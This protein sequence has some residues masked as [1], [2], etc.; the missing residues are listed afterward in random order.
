M[1]DAQRSLN[2]SKYCL[3]VCYLL[4]FVWTSWYG[5][6]NLSHTEATISWDVSGYYL[7]L[8]ATFIYQDLEQL[9]FFEE[10]L[11]TYGP[12]AGF[13][14]AFEHTSGNYILKYTLGQAILYAPAFFVAHWLAPVFGFP[15]DGFSLPYQFGI[16][17]WSI[18]VAFFG[19]WILRKSLLK[20]FDDRITG[21][22]L[23]TLVL[24]TNYLNYASI[25]GALT[26][27]YL[28]TLYALLIWGLIQW[29]EKPNILLSLLIGSCIG[30]AGLTRPTELLMV[31]LALTWGDWKGRFSFWAKHWVYIAWIIL[32]VAVFGSLQL[33][34]WKGIGGECVIYSYQE[35]GFSFFKP[36]I[37]EVLWS[38]RKGWLVYTPVMTLGILGFVFLWM[39]LPKLVPGLLL[40]AIL[41]FWVVASWD[42]WWYGGSFGQRALVQSYAV[43]AFPL[44]GFLSVCWNFRK[45]AAWLVGFVLLACSIVNQVQTYQAHTPNLLHGDHVTKAYFWRIFL[46]LEPDEQAQFLLDTDEEYRGERKDVELLLFEDFSGD[47]LDYPVA[48]IIDS[49]SYS[50]PLATFVGPD[51]GQSYLLEYEVK[52]GEF[53]KQ[54]VRASAQF[55]SPKQFYPYWKMPMFFVR[56]TNNGAVV[57]QKQIRVNRI[58]G[59]REWKYCFLDVRVPDELFNQIRVF[60]DHPTKEGLLIIDDLKLEGYNPQ[61]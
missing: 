34:Y 21:L 43:M 30:L 24:A 4:I 46:A 49:I 40:F 22:T 51:R 23:L 39:K 16:T 10:I 6:W 56:F 26:H 17:W 52:P 31:V 55:Y 1:Q 2:F 7:Y 32:S 28:F 14:Q 29:Y 54:W 3:L 53:D 60:V 57:K 47:S 19:L 41:N 5:K 38:Y 50:S 61:E 58:M 36:H 15:A 45:W 33:L 13:G 25:D 8:P 27:N 37:T 12:S 42:M 20:F 48:Y 11:N 9:A 35:Q 44:A 59:K 18:L